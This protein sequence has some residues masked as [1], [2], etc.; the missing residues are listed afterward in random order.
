MI[1]LANGKL[2]LPSKGTLLFLGAMIIFVGGFYLFSSGEGGTSEQLTKRR[3]LCDQAVSTLL[4]TKDLVEL[5]RA[6]FLV[7]WL[8]CGVTQRL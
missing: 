5:Q 1:A 4:T 8:D 3:A 6:M 7:R 2:R